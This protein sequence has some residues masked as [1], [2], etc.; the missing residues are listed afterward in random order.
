MSVI[1]V[2]MP[3]VYLA[4]IAVASA[5]AAVKALEK[6]NQAVGLVRVETRM[7][8]AALVQAA[9]Q[10]MGY[11]TTVE[12]NLI[13]A[14]LADSNVNMFRNEEGLWVA[15]FS[16][17]VAE[18]DAIVVLSALDREYGKLVQRALVEKL[19]ARLPETR[20]ALLEKVT[21]PDQSVT[22]T[23]GVNA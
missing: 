7:K 20:M 12:D 5:A 21:N 14:E 23:L 13:Q 18:A 22:L 2:L 9:L 4:P 19:E 15:Q 17:N 16:S 1:L 6:R 10:A 11:Q 3:I 8:S